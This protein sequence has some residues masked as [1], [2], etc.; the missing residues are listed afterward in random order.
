MDRRRTRLADTVTVLKFNG[1]E[2]VVRQGEKAESLFFIRKGR[3]LCQRRGSAAGLKMA[4]ILSDDSA[5][6][7]SLD[8]RKA[9]GSPARPGAPPQRLASLRRPEQRAAG[10]PKV[11]DVPFPPAQG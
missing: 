4:S 9:R 2:Y 6:S 3:V 5:P 10:R 1:G 11:E 7:A 8:H